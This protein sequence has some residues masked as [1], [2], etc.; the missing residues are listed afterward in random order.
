M[1][2]K[3]D[4]HNSIACIM[5]N[6]RKYNVHMGDI[7]TTHQLDLIRVYHRWNTMQNNKKIS[8]YKRSGRID[9]MHVQICCM[10][11]WILTAT[12]ANVWKVHFVGITRLIYLETI[13]NDAP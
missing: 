10:Q 12:V 7:G 2:N 3:R 6:S 11:S 8:I 4:Q 9:N 13:P 5:E 1:L